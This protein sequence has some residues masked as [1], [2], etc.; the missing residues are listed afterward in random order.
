MEGEV[1]RATLRLSAK[2]SILIMQRHIWLIDYVSLYDEFAMVVKLRELKFMC[3]VFNISY[4][5]CARDCLTLI[6]Q[7]EIVS[8]ICENEISTDSLMVSSL[9]F[10]L[11]Q[12][13]PTFVT[14]FEYGGSDLL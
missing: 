8:R 1:K 9:R 14:Q 3:S 11:N 7:Y 5:V 4:W 13:L 2:S 12:W 6:H 10:K